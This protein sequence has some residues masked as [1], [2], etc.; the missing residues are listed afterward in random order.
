MK[1]PNL[2]CSLI[3]TT[4]LVLVTGCQ[5]QRVRSYTADIFTTSAVSG[6]TL[7]GKLYLSG[8]HLRLDWG[9]FAEVYDLHDRKGWR[10]IPGSQSYEELGSDALSTWVPEMSG[11]SLCPH[12][13]VPSACRLIGNEMIDGRTAKKWDVYN[14]KGFHVYYWTD[15]ALDIT[16]QMEMG[17]AA[18]YDVKNVRDA[19]VADSLFELPAG[20]TR[21]E[22]PL[23]R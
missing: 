14:P 16:L 9:Q 18:K 20:Y 3:L 19:S 8:E 7:T 5:R 11:G 1:L 10:T 15:S 2:A 23:R 6:V 13:Q 17:D 21:V 4:T 22:T 12:T